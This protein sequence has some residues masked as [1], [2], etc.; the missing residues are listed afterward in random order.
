[1][2]AHAIAT[3]YLG[4]MGALDHA[5]VLAL[6]A[7]DAVVHSPLYG[8]TPAVEFYAKLFEDTAGADLTLLGTADGRTVRGAPLAIWYFRFDWTLRSGADVI[9]AD[10]VD[11]AELDG[12]GRIASLTIVYDTHDA[13][14][15]FA[16][17]TGR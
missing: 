11:L 5:R 4:A 9:G 17:A 10:M 13:R 16:K 2:D 15:V 8:E 14:P 6:F 7:E 1:M 12:D 3:E